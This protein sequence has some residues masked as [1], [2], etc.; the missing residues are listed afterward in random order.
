M[1]Q[2]DN[3]LTFP[4]VFNTADNALDGF[5]V[6][7]VQEPTLSKLTTALKATERERESIDQSRGKG[8]LPEEV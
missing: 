4:P 1:C 5:D 6:S 2:Q 8:K 7:E 3:Q